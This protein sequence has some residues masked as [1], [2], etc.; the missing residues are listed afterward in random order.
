MRYIPHTAED[1]EAMLARIGVE[2]LEEL[3]ACV[4]EKYRLDRPLEVPAAASEQTLVAELEALAARN[5]SSEGRPSFLG[6]G[7]YSHFI[8][9]VVDALVSRGE[10]T[11]SYTPYQPEISQGTLQ[12][13]F[14]WQTMIAWSVPWLISGW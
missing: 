9:S 4:P 14:E 8:P 2:S 1:V 12:A 6:A 11:T 3:F 13:I 10:F 5:A 7:L